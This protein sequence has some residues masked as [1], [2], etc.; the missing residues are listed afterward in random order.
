[1]SSV[2]GGEGLADEP[3]R[4]VERT[5]VKGRARFW[6]REEDEKEDEEGSGSGLARMV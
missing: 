5:E 2:F 1:M 4:V 3:E 6:P